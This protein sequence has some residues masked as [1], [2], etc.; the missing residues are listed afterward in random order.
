MSLFQDTMEVTAASAPATVALRFLA[1]PA[2]LCVSIPPQ[3]AWKTSTA[4]TQSSPIVPPP[5]CQTETATPATTTRN[6]VRR[7][8]GWTERVVMP[9]HLDT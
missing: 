7:A 8:W 3:S 5:T 1:G 2:T 9:V 6:A 4:P